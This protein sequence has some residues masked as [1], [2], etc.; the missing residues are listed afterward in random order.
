MRVSMI[1]NI[2]LGKITQGFRVR[3]DISSFFSVP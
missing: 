1:N 3:K 2:L